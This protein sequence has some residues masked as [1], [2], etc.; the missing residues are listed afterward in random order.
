MYDFVRQ[1]AILD[2]FVRDNALLGLDGCAW[3]NNA[4]IDAH[5]I[6]AQAQNAI[7]RSVRPDTLGF[8]DHLEVAAVL[9]VV[10]GAVPLR[11]C[12]PQSSIDGLRLRERVS[13]AHCLDLTV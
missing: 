2:Y 6:V 8:R 9:N 12:G 5:T 7:V 4:G 11:S 13:G 10:S 1:P 3:L